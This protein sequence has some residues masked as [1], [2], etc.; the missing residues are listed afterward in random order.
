MPTITSTLVQCPTCGWLYDRAKD[1]HQCHYP[2]QPV[3]V[4]ATQADIERLEKKLDAMLEA[5]AELKPAGGTS[6]G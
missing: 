1:T 5:M 6:N 3:Q 2:L 4:S